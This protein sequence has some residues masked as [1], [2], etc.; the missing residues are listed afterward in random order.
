[1]PSIDWIERRLLAQVC[2]QEER[3]GS[4]A[5]GISVRMRWPGTHQV[6]NSFGSSVYK[7]I[8]WKLHVKVEEA[9]IE[10]HYTES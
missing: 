8:P 3:S 5:N 4:L 7:S 6:I 1:M 10:S 9:S 2:P